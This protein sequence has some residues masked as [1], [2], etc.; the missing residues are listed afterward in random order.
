[1]SKLKYGDAP[2]ILFFFLPVVALFQ[3]FKNYRS[4]WSKN[5]FWA[6]VVFYGATYSISSE[7][8]NSE[9]SSDINRYVLEIQNLHKIDI[10]Y[11]KALQLYDESDGLDVVR[12]IIAVLVSRFTDSQQVLTIVYG[13]IFGFFYSRNIWFVLERLS[14]KLNYTL[15]VLLICLVLLN[16]MWFIGGFRFWTATHV[17][18]YGLMPY[19]L[20]KKKVNILVASLSILF[21]FSFILP[22]AI[23]LIYVIAGNRM[24][25]YFFIFILSLLYSQLNVQVFNSFINEYSTEKLQQK[26]EG[27]RSEDRVELYRAGELVE[28]EKNA[29]LYAVFYTLGLIWFIRIAL[30]IFFIKK[31]KE[32]KKNQPLFNL[33]CFSL[34]F[35]T[36]ANLLASVPSGGRYLTIA[37]FFGLS[38]IIFFYNVSIRDK[39]FQWFIILSM[40]ALLLFIIVSMRIGFFSLSVN[41]FFGNPITAILTDYNISMNDIIKPE[42][43]K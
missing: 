1:M 18:L 10:N 40:P 27:Y 16:P 4:A 23:L 13:F 25:I 9:A 41:T 12:L 30:I 38:T 32:L 17:F 24:Y 3:S 19:L 7:D 11:D 33:F 6:F 22:M 26:T 42:T 2:W 31:R 14:G 21:H 35:F 34:L 28:A 37:A 20:E 39:L 15:I 5:I 8:K 36:V 43:V 29:N